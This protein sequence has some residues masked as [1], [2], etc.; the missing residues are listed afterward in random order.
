MPS[1]VTIN[2]Q[3]KI[4][5][6]VAHFDSAIQV[7]IFEKR[8]EN[9]SVGLSNVEGRMLPVEWPISKLHIGGRLDVLVREFEGHL[10]PGVVGVVVAGPEVA[11]DHFE[12]PALQYLGLEG[13]YSGKGLEKQGV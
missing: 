3:V 5:F 9:K 1:S 8:V 11:D 13:W 12:G 4:I 10:V 7:S 6:E 2:P